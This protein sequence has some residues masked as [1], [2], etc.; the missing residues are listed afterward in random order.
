MTFGQERIIFAPNIRGGGGMVLLGALLEVANRQSGARAFLDARAA[1]V[2]PPLPQIDISWVKPGLMGR[3][4]SER[5]LTQAAG[6]T[7]K[8]LCFA[9][10]PPLLRPSG[11][12]LVYAQNALTMSDFPLG[13]FPAR[14][15]ARLLIER[16]LHRLLSRNVDEYIVQTTSMRQFVRQVLPKVP[17]RVVPFVSSSEAAADTTTFQESAA[18]SFLYPAHD[19]PHKNHVNLLEAWCILAADGIFPVLKLT[20]Q[21]GKNRLHQSI[22]DCRTKGANIRCV[23]VMDHQEMMTTFQSA[24]AVIYPSLI[25]S[26]GLPLLEAR[27]LGRPI[28]AAE[29]DYVRDVCEPTETFDPHSPRSIARAVKRMLTVIE[30]IS[31]PYS[32]TEAWREMM[33]S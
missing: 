30:P 21:D 1:T 29:L 14:T 5:D 2:L 26:F 17:V 25:E 7:S 6:S 24:N 10:V 33:F 9:G 28:V 27:Q 16:G 20:L 12:V 18:P 32:A 31:T 23:G 22:E 15:A 4:R 3:L 11:K 8:I 19:D 13:S